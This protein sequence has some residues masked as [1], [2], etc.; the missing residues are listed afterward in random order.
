MDW[1]HYQCRGGCLNS[2]AQSRTGKRRAGQQGQR[3]KEQW[4]YRGLGR[5]KRCRD[6]YFNQSTTSAGQ[7]G[8]R[9]IVTRCPS[10][11]ALC[12]GILGRT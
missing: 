1:C 2:L 6:T 9:A 4:I 8:V 10:V 7:Y 11:S 12:Q 5:A 3:N